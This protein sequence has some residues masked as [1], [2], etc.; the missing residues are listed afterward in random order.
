MITDARDATTLQSVAIDLS[1]LQEAYMS[2]YKEENLEIVC[3][4]QS[5]ARLKRD[6]CQ[7][8]PYPYPIVSSTTRDAPKEV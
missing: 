1:F 8:L 3:R 2:S 6:L 7:A 4:T 5:L